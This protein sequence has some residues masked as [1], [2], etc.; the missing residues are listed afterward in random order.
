MPHTNTH[1]R[2]ALREC[3]CK[4]CTLLPWLHSWPLLWE[5]CGLSMSAHFAWVVNL[6]SVFLMFHLMQ[7]ENPNEQADKRKLQLTITFL[8]KR[9]LSFFKVD[10][11]EKYVFISDPLNTSRKESGH[12]KIHPSRNR[13]GNK[14]EC[15]L[16][17][18]TYPGM[19]K[20]ARWLNVVDQSRLWACAE[21]KPHRV[22]TKTQDLCPST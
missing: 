7:Q 5:G 13:W 8:K 6:L 20:R 2:V 10:Y 18:W 22:V 3:V 1:M 17:A 11:W 12:E 19:W 9:Q 21:W 4:K 15:A 16:S 14:V